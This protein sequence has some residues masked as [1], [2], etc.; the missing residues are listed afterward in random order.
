MLLCNVMVSKPMSPEERA[1]VFKALADPRRLEIV[2]LLARGSQCGTVIAESL[3]ISVAL[4]CHHWEVLVDAGILRKERQGQ[5]RVC[6]LDAERLRDAMNMGALSGQPQVAE[7]AKAGS[8]KP[9]RVKRAPKSATGSQAP[10]P[11]AKKS[12]QSARPRSRTSP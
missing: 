12:K 11:P 7:R 10:R 4:L 1:K 2:E 8:A 5:L 3:G 6:S 9:V